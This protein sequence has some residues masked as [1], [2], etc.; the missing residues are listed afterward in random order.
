M[1]DLEKLHATY[2][3]RFAQYRALVEAATPQDWS[4]TALLDRIRRDAL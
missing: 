3:D 1:D 4:P 2:L